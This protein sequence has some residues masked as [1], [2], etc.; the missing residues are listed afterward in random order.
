MNQKANHPQTEKERFHQRMKDKGVTKWHPSIDWETYAKTVENRGQ[1][2]AVEVLY[3]ELNNMQDA[4]ERGDYDYVLDGDEGHYIHA[5][6]MM[7][8]ANIIHRAIHPIE[9]QCMK[10]Q[11]K[12]AEHALYIY[13]LIL[14]AM[15]KDGWR[16]PEHKEDNHETV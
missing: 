5:R 10:I 7:G 8:Y 15:Y 9:Q 2:E 11:Q 1:A 6:D 4:I 3:R 13:T 14:E 12:N 16:L